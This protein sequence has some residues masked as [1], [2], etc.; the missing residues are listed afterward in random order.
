MLWRM[1][2]GVVIE[3]S[4]CSMLYVY[5]QKLKQYD[6]RKQKKE[7]KIS[8]KINIKEIFDLI[9]TREKFFPFFGDDGY[10]IVCVCTAIFYKFPGS[11]SRNKKTEKENVGKT[12]WN[13]KSNKIW[14]VENNIKLNKNHYHMCSW[15]FFV[16][17][18]FVGWGREVEGF[19]HFNCCYLCQWLTEKE[20]DVRAH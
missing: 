9:K 6:R 15:M 1:G 17:C 19:K 4:V 16:F 12:N 10:S 18:V 13:I 20:N 3:W 11:Q 8:T 14:N 2:C 7:L 5:G